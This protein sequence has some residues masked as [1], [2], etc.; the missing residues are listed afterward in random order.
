M[1]ITT[2]SN[3]SDEE[4]CQLIEDLAA[5]AEAYEAGTIEG[6]ESV[7]ID[8]STASVDGANCNEDPATLPISSIIQQEEE[9]NDNTKGAA[10]IY[11][12]VL[13]AAFLMLAAILFVRRK[14]RRREEEERRLQELNELGDFEEDDE[15]FAF[16]AGYR[17]GSL[18]VVN[19]HKCHSAR[20]SS[21]TDSRKETEFLPLANVDKWVNQRELAAEEESPDVPVDESP[22]DAPVDESPP[23]APEDESV[24]ESPPPPPPQ[25]F[26]DVNLNEA[27]VESKEAE[28]SRII[29][30]ARRVL[31]EDSTTMDTVHADRLDDKLRG[32]PTVPE[33]SEDSDVTP[34]EFQREKDSGS[35]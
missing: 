35:I 27:D 2:D 7:D 11:P 31:A 32:L 18:N 26:Y 33:D 6:V 15:Q 3:T 19:V 5:F 17:N 22:P 10:A 14:R 8:L 9:E 12:F 30:T 16:G 1:S 21:C 13:A 4:I 34:Q 28:R 23:D 24:D 29:A 20:C 25:E